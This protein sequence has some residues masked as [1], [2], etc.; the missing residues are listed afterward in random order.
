MQTTF[1]WKL[2]DHHA[3][4][5][6]DCFCWWRFLCKLLFITDENIL[7]ILYYSRKLALSSGVF[8]LHESVEINRKHYFQSLTPLKFFS[9]NRLIGFVWFYGIST[10]I[11]YLMTNPPYT[12]K[13]KLAT[14]VKGNTK[15]PFSIA[16]TLRCRRGCYFFPWIAPLYSWYVPYNAECQARR[17]Q[18]PFFESLVW[19]DLGL[20]LVSQATDKHSTH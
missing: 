16:T 20:N 17:Y 3:Y 14:V 4:K 6:V 15:A 18:V 7:S 12:V 5:K 8:L 9:L 11:A 13:V 2:S 1:F 19:R 10:V